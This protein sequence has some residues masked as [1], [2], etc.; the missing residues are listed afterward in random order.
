MKQLSDLLD[1]ATAAA[2]PPR[3]DVEDAIAAGRR[4]QRRRN[5]GW[6]IAAVTAVAVA[7]GVPQIATR[8]A[9][10]P[11]PPVVI[12]TTAPA[13]VQLRSFDYPFAGY[14][15]GRFRIADPVSVTLSTVQAPIRPANS[16][17]ALSG[18]LSDSASGVVTVYRPGVVGVGDIF[19]AYRNIG[20]PKI[21]GRR[22]IFL[23]PKQTG[24]GPTTGMAWEYTDG[25]WVF[26]WSLHG[27][28]KRADLTQVVKRLQL[29]PRA[30][31]LAFRATYLP[32]GYQLVQV[33]GA[34]G[35]FFASPTS[36][37]RQ[38]SEQGL[39]ATPD[40]LGDGLLIR[41][42]QPAASDPVREPAG[43]PVCPK[44][45]EYCYRSLAGGY[46]LQVS[47]GTSGTVVS[48]ADLLRTLTA[49][50][51]ADP[52]DQGTWTGVNRALPASAQLPAG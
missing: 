6:A 40:D 39:V 50:T 45:A 18:V 12:P 26:V 5:T 10:P 4:L 44:A 21:N 20:N 22:A 52:E 13:P 28:L 1:E 24:A 2:P 30:A 7:I 19:G 23:Q 17:D 49:I 34:S 15:A 9:E 38:R 37:G 43:N 51:V 8:R 33:D 41:L 3:Y 36:G 16:P 27:R 48:P 14:T 32:S 25:G 42:F 47:T 11:V 29:K 46:V 31:R 35:A